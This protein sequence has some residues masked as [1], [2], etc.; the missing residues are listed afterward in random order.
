M[1]VRIIPKV[2]E[3]YIALSL[4]GDSF[5]FYYEVKQEPVYFSRKTTASEG[6]RPSFW[7]RVVI[8]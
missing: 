2:V 6:V 1:R 8:A 3:T 7:T 4:E 5:L